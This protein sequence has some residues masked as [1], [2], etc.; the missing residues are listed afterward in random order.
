MNYAEINAVNWSTLSVMD[1]SPLHYRWAME[2]PRADSDALRF[3]RAVHC[4]V[5]E[6]D[7]YGER[8]AVWDGPDRRTKAGKE[9]W[10]AFEDELGDRDVLAVE[11]ASTARAAA[12][13]VLACPAAADLLCG[14]LVEQVLAWTDPETGIN[15]KGRVDVITTVGSV[16]DVKTARDIS[17]RRFAASAAQFRYHGQIAFYYDG[18]AASGSVRG[19]APPMIIAVESQP[20]YDVAVYDCSLFVVPG[21]SLYRRLLTRLAECRRSDTWP[22][23]APGITELDLPPWAYGADGGDDLD[24]SGT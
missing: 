13:A 5:L 4:L 12:S 17:P 22:G 15:C 1:R 20:P 19:A 18:G 23:M 7:L 14:A 3:G 10:L 8:Y 24:W 2:H 16:V 11:T 21:R 6:P 9:Q